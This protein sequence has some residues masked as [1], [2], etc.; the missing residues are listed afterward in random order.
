VKD[1]WQWILDFNEKT[2]TTFEGGIFTTLL[3]WICVFIAAWILLH[4]IIF[5]PAEPSSLR[6]SLTIRICSSKPGCEI[7]TT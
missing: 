6:V 2:N 7:S 5:F 3:V 4:I 1:F